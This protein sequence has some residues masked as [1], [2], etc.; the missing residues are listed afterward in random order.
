MRGSAAD[1]R[2][3]CKILESWPYVLDGSTHFKNVET[4]S[5]GGGI[6]KVRV[7]S[8]ENDVRNSSRWVAN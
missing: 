6:V 8:F 7:A 1:V 4:S 3:A 5:S 2:K